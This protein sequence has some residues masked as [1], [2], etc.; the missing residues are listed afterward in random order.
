MRYNTTQLPSPTA[1]AANA[2]VP[3]ATFTH[4]VDPDRDGPRHL[5]GWAFPQ[6]SQELKPLSTIFLRMIKSLIAPSSSRLSSS[7]SP[8]RRRHEAGW[9][10]GGKSLIYFEIV[11]TLALFIAGGREH[12]EAG[13]RRQPRGRGQG[14]AGVREADANARRLPE[15]I[16][17]DSVFAAAVNNEVLQIVFW[18]ILFGLAS[19]R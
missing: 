9:A 5:V 18:S 11:T 12:H 16:V 7:A 4:P 8:A 6:A 17:P 15:L 10:A 3:P 2:E 14:G 19:P 13:C 1:G